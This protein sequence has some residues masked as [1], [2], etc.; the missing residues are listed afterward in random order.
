MGYIEPAPLTAQEKLKWINDLDTLLSLRLNIEDYDNIPP[1]FRD[2]RIESGRVTF[3]VATEFEVEL[4]IADEDFE[5][6]FWFID[7]RYLFG[8][9]AATIPDSLRSY[10]ETCVN[11]VLSKD[12]LSGCYKFLHEFVLTSKINELKR[13][14]IELSKTSWS[15]TL[16]V[17]PLNRA[18]AIQYWSSRTNT[19]G[20][21]NWVLIAIE[22]GKTSNSQTDAS[23]TSR[24]VAK[25]YR[26]NKEVKDATLEL[27]LQ[28]LSAESLLKDVVGRHIDHILSSIRDKL[29]EAPRFKQ[30]EAKMSLHLSRSDPA[31]CALTTEVTPNHST[32]LIMEPTTGIFAIK[33]QSKFS[34]QYEMQLNN[35]KNVAED[36]VLCV[37]NV[38]CAVLEDALNRSGTTMGWTTHKAP[39][40]QEEFRLVTK[41]R[42]WTRTIWIQK[43]GWG[44]N[45]Y[46]A[47]V[48][49]LSGDEWW[50]LEINRNEPGRACKFHTKLPVSKGQP[51]LSDRFWNNLTLFATGS[52]A[53]ITDLRELHR[54]R[55][56]SR[57]S[58]IKSSTSQQVKIPALEM[59]LSALVPSM[60]VDSASNKQSWASNIV[61]V[62]FGGL[63]PAPKSSNPEAETSLLM[64][65]TDAILKV[66]NPGKFTAL[67]GNVDHDL[68]YNPA[69]G[70]F[71]LRIRHAVGEPILAILQSRIKSIDR[72]VNF[73]EAVE[74]SEG[75]IVSEEVSLQRVA[76]KYGAWSMALD[77]SRGDI[78]I[79]IDEH[80]PHLRVLDLMRVLVNSDGGITA[81]LGWLPASLSAME[82][83]DSMETA[84]EDVKAGTAQ[85]AV[86]TLGWMSVRYSILGKPDVLT[87]EVQRKLRRGE[88]WWH[89]WRSDKNAEGDMFSAP[90][91]AVWVKNGAK[92]IGLSTGAAGKPDGGVVEMMLA[93]DEAIRRAVGEPKKEEADDVVLIE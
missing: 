25:W 87:L 42:D 62:Q 16:V 80:N 4:T 10:L 47:T 40:S 35:G 44:P 5:K 58:D 28:S 11:D 81:L 15:S 32:S 48:L 69:K 41:L 66:R 91:K 1:Q 33:P 82:A 51:S 76:F 67:D 68:S 3:Q 74:R 9:S 53:R 19:T 89:V 61:I 88:A 86:K 7:F 57:S 83:L 54:Q 93:T 37:E 63:Q 77:L 71:G 84:W 20:L 79:S 26:D 8:P 13:Q 2:Y 29:S 30:R 78:D 70:E 6:Q 55:I 36:G 75:A 17:E 50:L 22:S 92:W 12:G 56:K 31:A 39:L 64:C 45:W 34:V 27:D 60:A 18:L 46:I 14:A 59:D 73:L 43:E 72:F 52:I 24:L 21:K 23:T 65:T 85:F 90:L 49:S 38:R